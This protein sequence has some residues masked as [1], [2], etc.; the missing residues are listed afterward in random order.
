MTIRFWDRTAQKYARRP[1]ADEAAY[2]TKLEVTRGYFRPDMELLEFGCGTGSTAITHAPH[3]RHITAIDFSRPMLEIAEQRAKAAQV[4]NVTFLQADIDTYSA[5][6][7]SYD[8]VLAMSLL[9]LLKEPEQAIGRIH[10]MLKPGGYFVSSTACI[11]DT[12]LKFFKF[13][14]PLGKAIGL[15]PQ[16]AVFADS[17]LVAML[18]RQG[19]A[20]RHHWQPDKYAAVF[21]VAQKGQ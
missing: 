14:A 4:A 5:P 16:L 12:A 15:L 10:R 1:I 8:M 21:I 6:D 11:G 18:E 17:E 2:Q 19:F 7:S 13:I 3:V 20:I 9:H